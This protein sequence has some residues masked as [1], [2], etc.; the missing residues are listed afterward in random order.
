ML[1]NFEVILA[2]ILV[3]DVGVAGIRQKQRSQDVEK[4]GFARAVR[5]DH[6]ENLPLGNLKTH[7]AKGFDFAV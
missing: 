2:D 6:T 5:T 4:G 1:A 7:L 3:E